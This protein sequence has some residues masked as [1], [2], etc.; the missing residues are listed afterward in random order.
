MIIGNDV[1]AGIWDTMTLRT[2]YVIQ[3]V[4][5]N[6]NTQDRDCVDIATWRWIQ[7]RGQD[8]YMRLV[9]QEWSCLPI[10]K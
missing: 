10:Q 2:Q 9:D 8:T 1:H 6:G 4:F 7:N 3:Y 5:D